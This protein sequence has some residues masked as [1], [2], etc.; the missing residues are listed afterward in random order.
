MIVVA[1]WWLLVLCG[2]IPMGHAVLRSLQGASG[3]NLED[4]PLVHVF[5]VGLF[6]SMA[7]AMSWSLLDGLG[8]ASFLLWMAASVLFTVWQRHALRNY[9]AHRLKTWNAQHGLAR[10]GLLL[11]FVVALLK[12]VEPSELYDEGGYILPYIRWLEHYGVVP[13][14]AN[15]EDRFGFNSAW[16]AASALFSLWWMD[17]QD[18][19]DLNGLILVMAA[20]WFMGGA[21]DLL[22]RGTPRLSSILKV[23]SLLFYFRN[24]LTGPRPDL[25]A[26]LM[27][28][29]VLV[30]AAERMEA[31]NVLRPDL[32][33]K[34]LVLYSVC[35]MGVKFTAV[36]VG[37]YP[38]L[39]LVRMLVR[40][41][42]VPLGRLALLCTCFVVP[43]TAQNIVVS[44]Y[45]V[46]PLYQVDVMQVDWK[47]PTA[48]TRQQYYYVSEFAKSNA[49][50]VESEQLHRT[51]TL[52]QWVPVWFARE[53]AM[54]KATALTLLAS[55]VGLVV[56]VLG[57][58]RSLW[59]NDGELLLFGSVLVLT[60]LVWFL[61]TPAFRF[62]W[63]TIIG[64]IAFGAYLCLRGVRHGAVLR[65]TSLA[66]LA[67]GS[68]FAV[69]KTLTGSVPGIAERIITPAP[70]QQVA[71]RDR[72]LHGITVH[73]AEGFPCWG[74]A[75]PCF[76]RGTVGRVEPRGT[77]VK[78]GFRAAE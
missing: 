26:M 52:R 76:H 41:V 21:S 56:L 2:T 61:R 75:P 77:S 47:V 10:I 64:L 40:G 31:G 9:L 44:G 14:I 32:P 25:P 24:M 20:A 18:L 29:M 57:R 72:D 73:E 7:W 3:S 5:V 6:A 36:L 12:S 33:F 69:L 1:C 70:V 4:V 53:N 60:D 54:N 58:G 78:D 8:P 49:R 23:F 71:Y 34:L 74:T 59:R 15:L 30:L 11:V 67:L 22:R 46:Y 16:H 13:G 51:R 17:G 65:W 43:W 55:V 38:F 39:L 35:L 48:F 42:R 50:P 28:E 37:L 27:A 68:A 63:G 45:M 19:Y 62:G 66:L